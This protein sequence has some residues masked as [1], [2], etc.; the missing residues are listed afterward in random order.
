MFN[1]RA[2]VRGVDLWYSALSNLVA[3]DG[4]Y[5]LAMSDIEFLYLTQG[6]VRAT[7]VDMRMVLDAVEESFA[8][9]A[10]MVDRLEGLVG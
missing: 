2:E 7:G 5:W 3:T 9:L 6:D 4:G 1:A 8:V 10:K